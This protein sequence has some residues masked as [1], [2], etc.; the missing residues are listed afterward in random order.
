MSQLLII[1]LLSFII[2][3][4][5][6]KLPTWT[7]PQPDANAALGGYTLLP[8]RTNI[9]IFHGT[10]PNDTSLISG[11]YNH[12]PMIT[13][14]NNIFTVLWKN[15]QKDEDCNGQRILYSQ[16]SN[17]LNWT[18]ANI[19]FMNMTVEN[20]PATSLF[21]GPPI[22]INGHLYVAAS[23][24]LYN[25]KQ[26]HSTADGAQFCL[27]PEPLEPRNCGPP[28]GT[29]YKN[30][31]L[32][33]QVYEGVNNIGG[34]FW[35]SNVAP[36]DFEKAT[37]ILNISTIDQMDNGTQHDIAMLTKKMNGFCSNMNDNKSATL[38]CEVCENGC[39][40]YNDIDTDLNI[41]NE[42]THYILPSENK[43]VILYRQSKYELYASIRNITMDVNDNKIF[44][45]WSYPKLTNIPNDDTNLN[46]G[47]LP[48][49]KIYLLSNPVYPNATNNSFHSPKKRDPITLATS[50]DGYVFGKV[51]VIMTCT[52]LS[53]TSNCVARYEGKGQNNGPSYPQG[54]TI[55]DPAPENVQGL[56]VVA[57]NNKE[58]IFITHI[59]FHAIP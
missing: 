42:R 38:K 2:G 8:N 56:Y 28:K 1:L 36:N 32:M 34:L 19:M 3:F 18:S 48:N 54:I 25:N 47:A 33:R 27:Y 31:L 44:G 50:I 16:S 5:C 9:E 52:N 29:Q 24:G 21:V 11:A 23:P 41:K 53:A 51:G 43:D 37:K 39:Q 12:A 22:V 58:D 7:A 35:A 30:T 40:L 4:N 20:G 46:C 17:G 49:G 13:Y 45:N 6:Q 15:C 26:Y 57:S 10:N 55:I 59:P 14:N